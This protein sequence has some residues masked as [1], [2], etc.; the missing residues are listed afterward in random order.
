MQG[1]TN[2]LIDYFVTAIDTLGNVATTDIY[3][4]YVGNFTQYQVAPS[5]P[6]PPPPGSSF[7]SHRFP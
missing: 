3:H 1:F 4:V 7:E 2:V 5:N 6:F